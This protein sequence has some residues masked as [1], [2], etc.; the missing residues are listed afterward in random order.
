MSDEA[1]SQLGVVQRR[2]RVSSVF[3][4]GAEV[5]RLEA[6][7]QAG[8]ALYRARNDSK[9]RARFPELEQALSDVEQALEAAQPGSLLKT[10]LGRMCDFTGQPELLA[11][12][13]AAQDR[14]EAAIDAARPPLPVKVGDSVLL[15]GHLVRVTA[16]NPRERTVQVELRSGAGAE[17]AS[18]WCKADALV[19]VPHDTSAP[20]WPEPPERMREGLDRARFR[21]R[22][23]TRAIE[24]AGL[25]PE[26]FL[27][28][29][30]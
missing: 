10:S 6:L 17:S 4:E 1:K 5:R 26:P 15:G 22:T 9:R 27:R 8:H 20:P 21:M 30:E 12:W 24:E 18:D 29:D 19:P 28:A 25:E 14:I 3:G 7:L 13:E 11:R 16:T 2:R 23:L